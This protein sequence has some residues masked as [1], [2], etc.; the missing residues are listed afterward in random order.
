MEEIKFSPGSVIFK[1]GEF[2]QCFYQIQEGTAGVYLH[3]GEE[4]QRKLTDMEAGQFFG[5]MAIISAWPRSST[6]VAE[7]ALK[8]IEIPGD[9]LNEYFLKQPDKILDLMKQLGGRIRALTN[10]Y[11]E[12][13][14]YIRE[15]ESA[16]AAKRASLLAKI[17]K[18]R[19]VNGLAR[20]NK[21]VSQE[22]VLRMK[23][24]TRKED[25]PVRIKSFDRGQIIFREGDDG[26]YMY[27]IQYGSVGIYVNFGTPAQKKLT[28]LFASKFFGEMGLL[29]NE[30]R[31]ATA[32][33]EEDDTDLEI[34][35]AGDLKKLF[36]NNPAEVYMIL[37]HLADR[38]RKL[39]QDYEEACEK[40]IGDD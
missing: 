12:V 13:L 36:E 28:T 15:K 33:V 35:Q 6:V 14:A 11:N 29:E 31:S 20:A 7:T 26:A 40:A 16:D 23:E 24:F 5:E 21:G 22:A 19:E 30:K 8:V 9:D 32:V 38:L 1:E 27:A 39:T 10:D 34:I 37:S 2:G 25:S 3:Y 17:K 18:A 4:N